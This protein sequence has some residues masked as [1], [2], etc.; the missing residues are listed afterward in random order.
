[1]ALKLIYR[2]IERGNDT[3][4]IAGLHDVLSPISFKVK[5]ETRTQNFCHRWKKKKGCQS[6]CSNSYAFKQKN[7]SLLVSIATPPPQFSFAT[8][9]RE[10]SGT[11]G[12][13]A[14]SP[15]PQKRVSESHALRDANHPS[16]PTR[17]KQTQTELSQP[18]QSS[19][20]LSTLKLL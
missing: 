6:F 9:L 18:K 19:F 10:R 16:P 4:P 1:M 12:T 11:S 15:P 3:V 13:S 2:N 5:V 20:P 8:C 7:P 14:F 17:P